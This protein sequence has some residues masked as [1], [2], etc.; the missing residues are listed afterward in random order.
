MTSMFTIGPRSHISPMQH[1]RGF[2][3]WFSSSSFLFHLLD[4][5][6][7]PKKFDPPSGSTS[8]LPFFIALNHFYAIT[9]FLVS[10]LGSDHLPVL[11]SSDTLTTP[12]LSFR[13]RWNSQKLVPSQWD[14]WT[15]ELASSTNPRAAT[16]R[17]ACNSFE[18]KVFNVAKKYFPLR[19]SAT[20]N[21]WWDV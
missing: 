11:L 21:P 1:Y 13:T 15:A 14:N 20:P 19:S 16:A 9:V 18:R 10:F 2:P 3:I 4:P 6:D 5:P 7:L 12:R 17:K 8:N